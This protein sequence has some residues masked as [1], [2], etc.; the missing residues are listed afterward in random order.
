[1]SIWYF[2]K[3]KDGKTSVYSEYFPFEFI[4]IFTG[5]L[6]A[7]FGPRYFH[8]ST[9]FGVDSFTLTLFGFALF[10]ISKMSLFKKGVWS[11]WGTELMSKPF[12]YIYWCGYVLM[13]LGILGS[14]FFILIS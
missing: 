4:M 8:N 1:M 3:D 2:K 5:L 14:V 11:S 10:F 13:G 12:K 9:Q 6:A 7:M